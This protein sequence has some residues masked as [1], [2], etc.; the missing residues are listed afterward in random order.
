MEA[1]KAVQ[2]EDLLPII[3]KRLGGERFV[4]ELS[5][6]F[7]LLKD[8]EEGVITVESL[9]R[10]SSTLLGLQDL[11]DNEVESMVI[12]EADLDGNGRRSQSFGVLCFDVQI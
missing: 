12:K 10:N 11:N 2:F 9:K 3:M 5:N 8:E 1:K 4:K 6:G 7:E